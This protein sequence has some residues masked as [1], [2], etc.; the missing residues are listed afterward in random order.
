MR[1]Y[2]SLLAGTTALRS[3]RSNA[4]GTTVTEGNP[5]LSDYISS[6]FYVPLT[7]GTSE[8][9][10]YRRF[11]SGT[12]A[13]LDLDRPISIGRSKDPFTFSRSERPTQQGPS[14]QDLTV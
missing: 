1:Y 12:T 4:G 6:G 7:I 5:K 11:S 3:Y 10:Y 13:P 14:D 8:L 2:R 9:Q